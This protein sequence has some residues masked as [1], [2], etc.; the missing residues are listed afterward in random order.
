MRCPTCEVD[1][2]YICPSCFESV[3]SEWH[4]TKDAKEFSK[5]IK[6]NPKTNTPVIEKEP[7]KRKEK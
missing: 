5:M 7:E 4:S 1:C 3:S 6:E 2:S